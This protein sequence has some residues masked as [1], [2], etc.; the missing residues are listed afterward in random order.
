MTT[1]TTK[2]EKIDFKNLKSNDLK[3]F[4]IMKEILDKPKGLRN[5]K[6][7]NRR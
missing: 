3:N 1:T 2:K 5:V 7:P 6:N 4:I